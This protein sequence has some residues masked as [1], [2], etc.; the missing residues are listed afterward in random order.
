MKGIVTLR[1]PAVIAA[2]C[3]AAMLALLATGCSS[4]PEEEPSP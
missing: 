2:V 1:K 4:E 3:M